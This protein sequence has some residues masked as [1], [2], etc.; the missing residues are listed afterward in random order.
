M[1]TCVAIRLDGADLLV[2]MQDDTKEWRL[3]GPFPPGYRTL[4]SEGSGKWKADW[5]GIVQILGS[6]NQVLLELRGIEKRDGWTFAGLQ[7]NGSFAIKTDWRRVARPLPSNGFGLWAGIAVK[8]GGEVGLGA[9]GIL[10]VVVSAANPQRWFAFG[11]LSGRAGLAAGIGGAGSLVVLTGVN[12]PMEL[13]K[14]FQSGTD[15]ALSIGGRWAQM[16]KAVTGLEEL[17]DLGKLICFSLEHGDQL[18]TLG[19]GVYQEACLDCAEQNLLVVDTPAGAGAE[20]G[21]YYWAGTVY[22]LKQG[23]GKPAR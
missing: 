9:E 17:K 15:W 12:D 11:M 7:P 18:V 16:G 13:H 6:N 21:Y 23:A 4:V 5:G 2:E 22:V 20:L 19:K 8:G 3:R 14:S 10:A 1:T